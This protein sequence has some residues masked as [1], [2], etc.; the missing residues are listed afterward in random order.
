[1]CGSVPLPPRITKTSMYMATVAMTILLQSPVCFAGNSEQAN[2]LCQ[3][4]IIES[5]KLATQD[6]AVKHINQALSMEPKRADFWHAKAIVLER[7]EESEQALP[8]VNKAL[9]LNSKIGPY[10]I[11]K[12][13]I[14]CSL[15][16]YDEALISVD[17]G[18]K[19]ADAHAYHLT[20]AEILRHLR[21]FDLAEKELDTLVAK[22]PNDDIVRARRADIARMNK[23]WQKVIEDTSAVIKLH[24]LSFSHWSL[25]ERRAEAYVQTKQY[26]KAIA[27]YKEGIKHVP[28]ARQMHDELLKVY[29]ITGNSKG[30]AAE[31]RAIESIDKD[32]LFERTNPR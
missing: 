18:L 13:D 3:R 28:D 9:E 10:W 16:K 21:R 19:L 30:V 11:T 22:R 14:L 5:D 26:D 1:M 29:T 31:R 2:A 8:C 4:A 17:K 24:V 32:L 27:D 7:L 25:L 6:I 12:A 23:H 20:K 15:K